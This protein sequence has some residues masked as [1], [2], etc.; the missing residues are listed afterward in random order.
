MDLGLGR[1]G[2]E[3]RWQCE[4]DDYANRVLARHWPNVLRIGDVRD[5]RV[6]TVEPVDLICGGFPCQPVSVA[7]KQKGTGDSRWLW[8]EFARVLAEIRPR[9][10]LLEN[11]PGLLTSCGA[12]VASDLATLG[13]DAEW[14]C[15]PASSVGAWHKRDRWFCVAYAQSNG[16]NEGR[17]QPEGQQRRPN[18]A[19]CGAVA[20]NAKR[21]R[22]LP[23]TQQGIHRSEEI[24]GP[25]HVDAERLCCA[26]RSPTNTNSH[27]VRQQQ[28]SQRRGVDS[29][30]PEHAIR[31][32]HS[33]GLQIGKVF[34][35]NAGQKLTATQ[36]TNRDVGGCFEWEA[37]TRICGTTDGVPNRVQRLRG[38]GNAVVPQ[39]AQWIGERILDA[40]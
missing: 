19:E 35:G 12:I 30:K 28:V 26:Q 10:A 15:I 34:G 5:V 7:G 3:C 22:S 37:L 24:A 40:I 16:W 18:I 23:A 6:G 31:D 32:S 14:D 38:L 29:P 17:S 8:P 4:I 13:Y 21:S 20:A 11:V 27:A 1:A 39:V 36:R 33:Q 25:R 2:M 9:L